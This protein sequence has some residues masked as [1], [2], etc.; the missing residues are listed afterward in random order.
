MISTA[1]RPSLSFKS[2]NITTRSIVTKFCTV[3]ETT[4]YSLW[5]VQISP[6]DIQDGGRPASW[7]IEN[8]NIFAT[9]WPIWTKLHSASGGEKLQGASPPDPLT[10]GSALDPAGGLRPSRSIMAMSI[11]TL[12]WSLCLR[13]LLGLLLSLHTV[14]GRCYMRQN[15]GMVDLQQNTRQNVVV[16]VVVVVVVWCRR[17]SAV[18]VSSRFVRLGDQEIGISHVPRVE[19]HDWTHWTVLHCSQYAPV[20]VTLS[21]NQWYANS[22]QYVTFRVN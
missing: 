5:V 1:L 10:R 7:K 22:R 2:S 3:I 13:L 4:K 20:S 8:L 17:R 18:V 12:C 21:S 9:D 11:H 15:V 6:K 14:R 19:C 16:V